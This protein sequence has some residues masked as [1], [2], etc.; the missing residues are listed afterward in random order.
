MSYNNSTPKT[1]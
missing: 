1:Y